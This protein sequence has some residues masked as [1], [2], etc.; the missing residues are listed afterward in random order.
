MRYA[1]VNDI[2]ISWA[3]YEEV[4]AVALD[5]LPDGLIIHVA[6]PTDE[7]VRLIDI[8]ES[9]RAY[10]LFR[11]ERLIPLLASRTSSPA[12]SIFRDLHVRHL[13][14]PSLPTTEGSLT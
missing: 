5:H 11:E 10:R 14:A 8:W 12:I 3:T 13:A 9:E 4:A 1:L 7:G 6:G 2:P